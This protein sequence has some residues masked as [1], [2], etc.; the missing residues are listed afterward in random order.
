[1]VTTLV[2]YTQILISGVHT[3]G[4][5]AKLDSLMGRGLGLFNVLEPDHVVLVFA[6]EKAPVGW[7]E[8]VNV[9][10][11]TRHASTLIW[12]IRLGDLG[13]LPSHI[14]MEAKQALDG[15]FK[16]CFGS[17]QSNGAP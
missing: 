15:S 8:G 11:E 6:T 14:Q 7:L 9:V 13:K 2:G 12:S 17:T 1:M 4:W 3:L 10:T 5:S 16:G